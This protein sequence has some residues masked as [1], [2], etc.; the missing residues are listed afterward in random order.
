MTTKSIR[1]NDKTYVNLSQLKELTDLNMPALVE[2]GTNLLLENKELLTILGGCDES[3][4]SAHT[5][6]D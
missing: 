6:C 5:V 4:T 2:I 1:I 3:N